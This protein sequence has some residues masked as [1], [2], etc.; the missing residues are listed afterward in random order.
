MDFI[1]N[2]LLHSIEITKDFLLHDLC[3]SYLIS[4]ENASNILE[5]LNNIKM[6]LNF[7]NSKGQA[8]LANSYI[9][10]YLSI[11]YSPLYIEI[12]ESMKSKSSNKVLKLVSSR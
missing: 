12:N 10:D 8:E 11:K 2:D 1:Y 7:A 4:K 6:G 3:S 5:Q 9:S